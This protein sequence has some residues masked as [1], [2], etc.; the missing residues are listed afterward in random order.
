MSDRG[1]VLFAEI[2][3]IGYFPVIAGHENRMDDCRYVFQVNIGQNFSEPQLLQTPANFFR[4][5]YNVLMRHLLSW[6]A[7]SG[8]GIFILPL[9]RGNVSILLARLS[10]FARL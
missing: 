2:L 9:P 1:S 4:L 5:L 10:E 6:W 3:R 8:V 7:L